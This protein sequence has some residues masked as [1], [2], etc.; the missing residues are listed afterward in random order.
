MMRD[1]WREITKDIYDR[2]QKFGGTMTDEDKNQVFSAAEMCG[3]GIY[4]CHTYQIGD[5]FFVKYSAG[6]SCDQS[7]YM[8]EQ[9]EFHQVGQFYTHFHADMDKISEALFDAGYAICRTL[10]GDMIIMS[11]G[12]YTDDDDEDDDEDNNDGF[13][14]PPSIWR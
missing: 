2:S 8:G 7:M 13:Y 9:R 4:G 6:S 5:K 11:E 3:Y 14:T 1:E 10:D 12:N